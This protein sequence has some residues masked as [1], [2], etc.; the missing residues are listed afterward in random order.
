MHKA[1]GKE[2]IA[3]VD[4]S[5]KKEENFEVAGGKCWRGKWLS[6]LNV[7]G[8]IFNCSPMVVV[9]IIIKAE[10][11]CSEAKKFIRNL[12]LAFC[13]PYCFGGLCSHRRCLLQQ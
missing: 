13:R 7:T 5:K 11:F 2:G 1:E 6:V 4:A 9:F 10:N 12:D 8:G 3:T